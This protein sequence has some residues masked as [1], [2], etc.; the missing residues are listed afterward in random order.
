[1]GNFLGLGS[2]LELRGDFGF[3]R[4]ARRT[5]G[6]SCATPTCACSAPA[7]ASTSPAS[8]RQRSPTASARSPP[9]AARRALTRYLT[10]TLRAVRALRHLPGADHRCGFMRVDGPNDLATVPDNTPTASSSLG[11]VWDRRVGADGQPNP[12]APVKGWLLSRRRSARRR[13]T[14]GRRSPVPASLS[15]QVLA[16]LPFKIRG[17]GVHAHRQP[18]LRRG[19]PHRRAGAAAGRALLRRRRHHDARLRHRHAQDRDHPH[20]RLAA[21]RAA[22]ASASSRRAATSACSRRSSCSSRSP[23]P[24]SGCRCRGWARSST[25]WARSSNALEPRRG[26]ATS[27][28]RSASSF[29][30]I[31]TPVGPLSLEY[32]YPLTQT[33][34]EERWKTNPWYSHFPGRIHFNWGIPLSR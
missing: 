23:R 11:L 31:L 25:T 21:A 33:L 29:L 30:R 18:A 19:H 6:A 28:T 34:A 1:M 4:H 2:Q 15:A 22:P 13:R 7:G 24:S 12:L 3:C 20:R 17:V 16:L 14:L 5:A 27:S 32:A 10:P 9:T 26:A 8:I